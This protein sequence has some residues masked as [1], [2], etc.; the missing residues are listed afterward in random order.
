MVVFGS[1]LGSVIKL[2]LSS[3]LRLKSPLV[4]QTSQICSP[5][6]GFS[7]VGELSHARQLLTDDQNAVV[8]G[9]EKELHHYQE[10]EQACERFGKKRS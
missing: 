6:A 4:S 7:S 8:H 3:V 2:L 1:F 5:L 10:S 9:K